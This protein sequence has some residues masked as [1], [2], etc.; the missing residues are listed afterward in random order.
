MLRL[1]FI[2]LLSTLLVLATPVAAKTKT[3]AP[4]GADRDYISALA[5]ANRFLHAWQTQDHEAGL[6]MLTD[7]AKQRTSESRLLAFFS[8]P[9]A[10]HQ[11]FEIG[12]GKKLKD[13][14]YSF[15]IALFVI[16]PG[17]RR[18]HPR[19]SEIVVIRTGGDDWSIDKL[20]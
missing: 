17:H 4:P 16:A 13:G 10:T 6:V 12:R 19:F 2:F 14:R 5:A 15:P 11:A 7:A 18:T 3:S 9:P 1:A 20:P 8:P